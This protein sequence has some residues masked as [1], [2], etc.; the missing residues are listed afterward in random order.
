MKNS[1]F[2]QIAV[3]LCISTVIGLSSCVDPIEQK[4][5]Y[6]KVMT[7]HM[8]ANNLD[9][10]KMATDWVIDAPTMNTTGISNFYII[11]LRSATDF[12]KGH[13]AG[14]VNST[15]A[16][17]VTQAANASGKQIVVACYTGQTAA[18]ANV[19][20]RLSGYPT[21]KILKFGMSSWNS[22]FDSWTAN[23]SNQATGH[24]NWSTTNTIKTPVNFA[25][26]TFEAVDTTGAGILAERVT[27]MLQKGLQ[28]VNGAEVLTT[29]TNYFINNYWT[30][31][32][33]NTYGH[34][35][36]AYRLNETLLLANDGI[37][38]LDPAATIVTYCWTGQTAS[39][40]NA[41]LTVLGYEA[42]TLK[43]G[44]NAL[45][46]DAL[47]KNKWTTSGSFEYVE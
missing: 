37:K 31:A 29:P 22:N 4:T 45:V 25:Y 13:I 8:K 3:V 26:P 41:W 20:L 11:D 14:A 15:L 5:D 32:D 10:N 18:Y 23:I 39:L 35:K 40:V 7:D 43:F 36:G 9:L 33:V 21:S 24:A 19:A 1:I 38:N 12:A 2:S 6:F 28:M 42:K 30:E 16:N 46:H 17:V 47:L 44:T 34:I 27:F